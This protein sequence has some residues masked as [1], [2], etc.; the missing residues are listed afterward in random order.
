MPQFPLDESVPRHWYFNHPVP[1]HL[2]NSLSLLFPAGER[3]FMRSV[4]AFAEVYK[5]DPQLLA[6][7]RTFFGQEGSHARTHD[8]YIEMLEKQG[9]DVQKFLKF[10]EFIAYGLVERFSSP[11]VR[12][13][14]TAAA[15]HFTALLAEQAFTHRELDAAHPVIRDLLMWHAA[16]EVE[17]R[18]VAFD[19]L[20]RV[21]KSY[22]LRMVGLAIACSI[23]GS[24]WAMGTLVLVAQEDR[25]PPR[26]PELLAFRKRRG[27]PFRVLASGIRSYMRRDFH[28]NQT[29]G[30]EAAAEFLAS[31]SYLSPKKTREPAARPSA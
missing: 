13:A 11:K 3:F 5:N 29:G 18:A 15:E 30:D 27:S 12:L 17:H 24:F 14:S 10:Y 8:E 20:Q 2:G 7:V 23:L 4:R 22:A 25:I 28:P 1:T 9:Y 16:E 21:D 31:L 26:P 19:V 6:D